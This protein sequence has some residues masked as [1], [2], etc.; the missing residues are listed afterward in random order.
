[1]T[2]QYF[3]ETSQAWHITEWQSQKSKTQHF[4]ITWK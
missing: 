3:T 1:M 2:E 4:V